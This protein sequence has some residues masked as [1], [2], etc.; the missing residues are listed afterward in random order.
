MK[1][2]IVVL[3]LNLTAFSVLGQKQKLTLKK[4]TFELH[5]VTGSIIDFEGKKV[6]KIERDLKAIPFDSTR[7][8]ATVDEPHYARLMGLDDLKMGLLK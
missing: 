7:L 2:I 1:N 6:L 3:L 5:N 4:Q 8:E